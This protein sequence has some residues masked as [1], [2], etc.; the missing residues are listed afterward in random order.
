M[1]SAL[2]PKDN[3]MKLSA[4]LLLL[5]VSPAAA[6]T[7][8]GLGAPLTGPDAVFGA[9]LRNGVEQAVTDI[10]AKGGIL[11]QHL[12]LSTGDD[13]SDPKKGIAVA[14][15]FAAKKIRFVVGHFNSTVTLAASEIYADHGILDITPTSVNPQ[16]TERG[17]DLVFRTCG[18]DDQQAAV[19]AKFLASQKNNPVAIL[20]DRTTYGKDLAD[21]T[22]SALLDLGVK[23]VLYDGVDKGEKDYSGIVARIKASGAEYVYWGGDASDAGLLVRQMRAQGVGAVLVGGD[24]LA[25]DDFS[26]AGGDAAERALMTLPPDPRNEPEAANVVKHF[27]ARGIDPETYT[28]YAY[29]AVEVIDQAAIA[30]GSADPAAMAKL[31]HSGLPFKTV[32]G[33]L[34]FDAKGDRIEPDYVLFEWKKQPNGRIEYERLGQ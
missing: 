28:L 26:A 11:G 25:S 1:G 20:H 5:L 3:K 27:R 14:N 18:R 34:S 29:A 8:I 9:E 30:A 19:A 15:A 6:E 32:L 33:T 16:V 23:D 31:M 2:R 12:V 24:A 10:N 22:R 4:L 13:G 7:R 21:K 17:L